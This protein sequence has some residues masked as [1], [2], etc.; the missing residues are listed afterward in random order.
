MTSSSKSWVGALAL[1]A[2]LLP[3][4]VAAQ[5]RTPPYWASIDATRAIMRRGPSQQMR[6][7]WEYRRPGLPVRVIAI[8]E[9][10]RQ[11]EEQDGTRGWMHRSLLS[12]RRTAVVLGTA[13]QPVR[14]AA[15]ADAALA[16]RV[17][18]GTVA[19]IGS[20]ADGWCELDFG[21]GRR[22]FIPADAIWGD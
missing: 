20:C 9:D 19:A 1:V 7:M 21:G 3:L 10:W 14:A 22:G 13:P 8:H 11:V 17:A 15:R 4:P 16:Y 18:P 6:A 12:G 2:A 5:E